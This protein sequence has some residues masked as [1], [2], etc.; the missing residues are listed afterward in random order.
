MN[1]VHPVYYEPFNRKWSKQAYTPLQRSSRP[2][3]I[4]LLLNLIFPLFIHTGLKSS[5]GRTKVQFTFIIGWCIKLPYKRLA[6][7]ERGDKMNKLVAILLTIL[8]AISIIG[9]ATTQERI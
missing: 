3:S 9:Y 7:G 1:F 5:A 6:V 4:S 2:V 8:F